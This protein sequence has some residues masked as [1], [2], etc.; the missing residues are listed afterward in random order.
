ME[1]VARQSPHRWRWS[2]S[3][4]F[5]QLPFAFRD[6]A[7]SGSFQCALYSAFP[8][9]S[10]KSTLALCRTNSTQS[11]RKRFEITCPQFSTPCEEKKRV[12]V[13]CLPLLLRDCEQ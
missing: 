9:P 11:Q 10:S 13:N 7:R 6:R 1:S 5:V 8:V 3:R 4:G 12:F 2:I